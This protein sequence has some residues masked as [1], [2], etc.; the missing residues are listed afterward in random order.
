MNRRCMCC[1]LLTIWGCSQG[2][3]K[4]EQQVLERAQAA[5]DQVVSTAK[6]EIQRQKDAASQADREQLD[7]WLKTVKRDM[8]RFASLLDLVLAWREPLF[9][10]VADVLCVVCCMRSEHLNARLAVLRSAKQC[11]TATTTTPR[12]CTAVWSLLM[13][14]SH[15]LGK[16]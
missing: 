14:S 1:G 11:W 5:V 8:Y 10:M 2:V 6:L 7:R 12:M 16:E 9:A 3:A 13:P 15:A 4:G